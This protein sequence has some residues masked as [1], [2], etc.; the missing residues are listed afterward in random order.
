MRKFG[1]TLKMVEIPASNV[2]K[3]ITQ[4][5]YDQGYIT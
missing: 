1:K 5:L 3:A 4:I 2:K